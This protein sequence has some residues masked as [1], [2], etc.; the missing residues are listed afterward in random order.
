[1]ANGF[2]AVWHLD[3]GCRSDRWRPTHAGRR[4]RNGRRRAFARAGTGTTRRRST[5]IGA[6]TT[7]G[8]RSVPAASGAVYGR[9]RDGA[10]RSRRASGILGPTIRTECRPA[11]RSRPGLTAALSAPEGQDDANTQR[12]ALAIGC[13][14]GGDCCGGIRGHDACRAPQHEAWAWFKRI[15]AIVRR[16]RR[17]ARRSAIRTAH[18]G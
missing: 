16:V 17:I 7:G 2:D 3:A 4:R 8:G 12:C 18:G 13:R 15:A 14:W 6:A 5:R 10:C 1:M 11:A 9:S